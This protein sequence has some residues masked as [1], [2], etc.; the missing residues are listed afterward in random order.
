[1]KSLETEILL[2]VGQVSETLQVSA[3]W[4]Q[5]HCSRRAPRLPYVKVGKLLRFRRADIDRFI[6]TQSMNNFDE[7][8]G[9]DEAV[10]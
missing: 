8:S 7:E 4:V 9:K 6:A 2:T 10:A 1:V 5:A 3:D